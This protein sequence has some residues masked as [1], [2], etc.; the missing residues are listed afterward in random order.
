MVSVSCCSILSLVS[1]RD[2]FIADVTV[3]VVVCRH[4]P[5]AVVFVEM[6]VVVIAIIVAVVGVAFSIVCVV[7][8][9]S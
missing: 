7:T 4:R 3:D 6:G 5:L 8:L 2:E 1:F 9:L